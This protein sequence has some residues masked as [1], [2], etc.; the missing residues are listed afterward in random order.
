MSQ[1]RFE[2]SDGL[3][4][5]YGDDGVEG[6]FLLVIKD[7]PA[8]VQTSSNNEVAGLLN[9]NIILDKMTFQ[10]VSLFVRKRTNFN[11]I[12]LANYLR[13]WGVPESLRHHIKQLQANPDPEFGV[14]GYLTNTP[15]EIPN[16]IKRDDEFFKMLLLEK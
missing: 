8:S 13:D 15:E 14:R 3:K 12:V 11:G 6:F 10:P 5:M 7:Q 9:E 1:F 2:A 4:I 16:P